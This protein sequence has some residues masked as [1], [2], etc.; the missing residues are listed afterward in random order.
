MYPFKK[1]FVMWKADVVIFKTLSYVFEKNVN[2]GDI[3]LRQI[4][5]TYQRLKILSSMSICYDVKE[6][7]YMFDCQKSWVCESLE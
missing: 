1:D 6:N 5:P 7:K 4:L 3:W 2:I